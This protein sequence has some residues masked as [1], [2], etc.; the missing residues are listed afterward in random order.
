MDKPTAKNLLAHIGCNH[1]TGAYIFRAAAPWNLNALISFQ[2]EELVVDPLSSRSLSIRDQ[3]LQSLRFL[4]FLH[5]FVGGSPP[6][7]IIIIALDY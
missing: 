4:W 6:R 5:R 1:I 2:P 7:L 3:C